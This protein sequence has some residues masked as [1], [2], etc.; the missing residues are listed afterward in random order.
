MEVLRLGDGWRQAAA[1]RPVAFAEKV[2]VNVHKHGRF[3]V[4]T[5]GGQNLVHKTRGDQ[6]P[7][8]EAASIHLVCHIE[9][10]QCMRCAESVLRSWMVAYHLLVTFIQIG[11]PE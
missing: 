2:D 4:L 11:G 9:S 8:E 1:G 10:F 6:S 7:S 5:G 3:T